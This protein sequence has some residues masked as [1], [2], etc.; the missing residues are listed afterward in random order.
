MLSKKNRLNLT[1]T[2]I[3]KGDKLHSPTLTLIHQP[4]QTHLK[5]A[6]IVSK[7]ISPK[8][9]VRN[10]VRRQ[11]INA[12]QNSLSLSTPT[13]LIIIPKQKITTTTFDQITK[14]ISPLL[15]K[16]ANQTS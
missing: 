12:T 6:V 1:T 2:P 13:N 9:V 14:E 4:N 15:F 5:L 10:K 16:I 8:A 11:I 7:K 3:P